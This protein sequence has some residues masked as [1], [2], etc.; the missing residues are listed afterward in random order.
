MTPGKWFPCVPSAEVPCKMYKIEVP[1]VSR[2]LKK[3]SGLFVSVL[4]C[5]I[6][7]LG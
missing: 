5:I 4:K 7:F 1:N 3:R 6:A 2:V